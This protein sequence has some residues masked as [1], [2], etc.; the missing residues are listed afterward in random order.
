[1][2]QV[3]SRS[4]LET[5]A[6]LEPL[7]RQHAAEAEANRGLHPQVHH[8]MLEAGLFHMFVP[9]SQG[10]LELDVVS[11]FEALEEV[12]RIDSAAGWNL[13]IAAA[14][15]GMAAIFPDATAREL[16]AQRAVV[17]GGFFPP[18]ALQ[19]VEGGFRLNGRWAFVSGCQN[20]THFV[21]PCIE[22]KD[23]APVMG[24]DGHPVI[25]VC[26][27]PAREATVIDTWQPL[28]MR[29]TGSHDVVAD[30]IFIPTERTAFLRPLHIDRCEAFDGPFPNLG[31]TPTL[32]GNAVV[33]LGI[34]RAAIDESLEIIRTKTPAHF[35]T[36]PGQRSTVQAHLGRA[37]ATLSA[38]RA[39]FYDSLRKAWT[40]AESGQSIGIAE[41]KHLQ[42]AASYAAESAA[43]A[44]DYVHAAVGSTGVLE[45]QHAFARHFRD[46]HTITQHALCSPTR[47][48]SMGQIM[49]GMETDWAFF[50]I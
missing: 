18:G 11:G 30:N 15:I 45:S 43:Q 48:E 10:G 24:P 8:A 25:R 37:E 29:G 9:R 33:G 44:V 3:I 21:N 31:I 27:Y 41:R 42:L 13:Q 39:Y 36:Q 26:I 23:G 12:S 32:L 49:L 19:A 17:A 2:T 50:H 34:A 35:Q 4:V 47:F 16:F 5:V 22:L 14:P 20:A 46:V 1:M 7:I 38:A 6:Q 40:I 28:G